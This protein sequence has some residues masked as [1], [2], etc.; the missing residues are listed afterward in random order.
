MRP[1]C[2]KPFKRSS[3]LIATN[4]DTGNLG[5]LEVKGAAVRQVRKIHYQNKGETKRCKRKK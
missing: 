5:H 3:D 4:P 2:A 1:K